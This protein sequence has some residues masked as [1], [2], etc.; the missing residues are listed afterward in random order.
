MGRVTKEYVPSIGRTIEIEE[1]EIPYR[2]PKRK[3]FKPEWVKLPTHWSSRLHHTKRIET[4]RLAHTILEEVFKCQIRGGEIV[5][6][7]EVTRMSR[8]CKLNAARDLKRL[9][10]IE[11]IR[12]GNKALRVIPLLY[13]TKRER[14]KKE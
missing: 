4:Y 10:L 1:L 6:S 2:K 8:Q 14:K 3:Q 7:T 12:D 11:I 5:L 9:G 13:T